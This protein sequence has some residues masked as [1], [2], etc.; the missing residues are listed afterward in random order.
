VSKQYL[1]RAARA[2]LLFAACAK[3]QESKGQT[4]AQQFQ[5][6]AAQYES[7]RLVEAASLLEALLP[8]APKNFDVHELLGLVYA[9]QSRNDKAVGQLRIAVQLKPDSAAARANLAVGLYRS[10]NLK[11]AEEQFQQALRLEPLN[12][13]ANRNLGELYVQ[14]GRTEQ[15]VPLLEK[16]QQIEPGYDNGYDLALAYYLSGK[17]DQ[18]KQLVETL[19]KQGDRGELHNLLGQI[20]EKQGQFLSAANEYET[21]AHMDPSEVN[22]FDWGSELLLHRTYDPAIEVFQQAATR[23]PNSTRVMIG[24]GM[25]LYGRGRYDEA[26]E[27]LLKATDLSPTDAS[28]YLFLFKIYDNS[29]KH[30]EDSTQRFQ[31]YSELAPTNARAYYYYAASLWKGKQTLGAN[32]DIKQVQSLLLKSIA[33]DPNFADSHILMGN[34][35]DVQGQYDKSIPEYLRAVELN[36]NLPDAHYR[37]SQAYIRVGQKE[38]ANEEREIYQKLRSQHMAE[39]DKQGEEIQQFV[40][41]EKSGPASSPKP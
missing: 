28:G 11:A 15:A 26:V 22:L 1:S 5:S 2:I 21:A 34:L 6:A 23:Y 33:L 19:A 14:T 8:Q 27:S 7:G 13:D 12:Y 29:A 10:G 37:L 17:L 32:P 38:R 9:A 3:A 40:Y 25:A 35:Y 24:L 36:A 20:D 16:A 30:I 18:A 31:H 4:L 41:A 39:I